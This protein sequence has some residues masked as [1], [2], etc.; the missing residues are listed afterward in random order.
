MQPLHTL[1]TAEVFESLETS[2]EGLT[3]HE[4]ASRL[5]FYGH[6]ALAEPKATPLWQKFTS[7]VAHP[8]ALMLIAVGLLSIIFYDAQRWLGV[9]ILLI[10]LLNASFAFWQEYRAA[11]A[12]NALKRLLPA[13]ARV[14]RDGQELKVLASDVV[15]GDVLVLAE[16]D[17]ISADARVI[18]EYGLRTNNAT[19]TGEATPSRKTSES[20]LREGLTEVERP[21][22]IFAGT[23]VFSGTARAVVFATGMTTQF[24]RIANLTQSVKEE[25][26]PLMQEMRRMTTRISYTAIGLGLLIFYVVVRH[27]DQSWWEGMV[28]ALGVIVA[29]VPEGLRPT[30]TLTLAMAVRRLAKRG[31][32]VKQLAA[33]ETLGTISVL[34]TDKSGTLTQNQ[35]TA[36]EVWVSRQKIKVSGVGY[37]P[38]GKFS[39]SPYD[40]D[41]LLTAAFLCN[42]SRLNPP[43]LD[44]PQWTVLGDQTEAALRVLAIKGGVDENYLNT[45]LPRIHELP[46]DARRKRMSTIHRDSRGDIAF[47]KGAPKEIL[48]LCTHIVING[49]EVPIDNT[50]RSEILAAND[51]YARAALR[52]LAFAR[53]QLPPRDGAYTSENVERA[54]TFIGLVGMMDPPR[55]EIEQAIKRLRDGKVRLAMITGDYGL[56]AES[57]ARRVGML[58][59][60]SPHILTGGELDSMTDAQV[61]KALNEEI[62][63]ARMAPEHKMRLIDAFQARGDVVAMSG[64]GVNDAPALR[65][66]DIG[67]AMGITG[68]DVAK[69]AADV[70][71]TDDNFADIVSAIEEGRAVYDNI[72]KFITYIFSSNVP[73]IIPFVLSSFFG[74]IPLALSVFQILLIDAGT[75]ILPALALGTEKPEPTVM[76]RKPR[77]RSQPLLDTGLFLRAFAWLGMIE[78]IL[79]YIGF[80]WVYYSAGILSLPLLPTQPRTLLPDEVVHLL[81][82]TVYFIGVLA[83][84]IG[85]AFTCRTEVDR[86]RELGWSK[87]RFLLAG[88]VIQIA[89]IVSL[90]VWLI[91]PIESN[92]VPSWSWGLLMVYP[93]MI[94]GLDRVRKFLV[95]HFVRPEEYLQ[96]S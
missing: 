19:L 9:L 31:V 38:S 76:K 39:A 64:D 74:W 52:V 23:S 61:Q 41:Q 89:L 42:N 11:T 17:N 20:S 83:A 88:V 85:N 69:E 94:F 34:C 46:F 37:E 66:A 27:L 95:R 82:S 32:L 25:P 81:A 92:P 71:L 13:Y 91:L 72:R 30:L 36:R 8:M 49:E 28:F 87:N 26:S 4:A 47:V 44:R 1:R 53:R 65:K 84:Q 54:L 60:D 6:N 21:N 78:A 3:S 75:D 40:L 96:R 80:V 48:Q 15:P 24:G 79:C 58:T 33:V 73:Q 56:T 67:V 51:D 63:F 86:V 90:I 62:I 7:Q 35:M 22:L 2:A 70:I 5:A 55:P 16:G 12:V 59:S 10:V 18:E 29:V 50:I 93:L 77:R 43:T 14:I 45:T 57:L 68:S